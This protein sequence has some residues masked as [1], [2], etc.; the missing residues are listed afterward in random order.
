MSVQPE[1]LPPSDV[2]VAQALLEQM[3]RI[4]LLEE[5]IADLRKSGDIQGSVHYIGDM[6]AYRSQAEIA[7]ARQHEPILRLSQQL[8]NSGLNDKDIQAIHDRASAHIEAAATRA[9]Q[10]PLANVAEVK[11]HLYA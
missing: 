2:P 10:A 4:R 7:L 6:Q 11:E 8:L 1:A 5:K 9:L 3:I